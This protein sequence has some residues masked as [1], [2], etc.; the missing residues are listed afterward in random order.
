[1]H[2]AYTYRLSPTVKQT[3]ALSRLFVLQ[4]ELFNAALEERKMTYCWQ[5]RGISS[6]PPPHACFDQYKT[7]TGLST[8][9]PEFA[10]YGVTVCR[11]PCN[12]STRPLRVSS[13]A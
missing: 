8:L 2:R 1:M 13:A 11:G 5:K 6:V 7:L 12:A 10:P 9:R 3:Q 4:C